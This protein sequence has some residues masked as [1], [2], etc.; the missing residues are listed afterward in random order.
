M[1]TLEI[2]TKFLALY[3]FKI[4]EDEYTTEFNLGSEPLY[5][6]KTIIV[7]NIRW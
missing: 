6:E 5:L 1:I 4:K 2:Y 3:A 7:S